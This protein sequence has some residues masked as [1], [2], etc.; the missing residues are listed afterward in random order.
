[1]SRKVKKYLVDLHGC[2]SREDVV[3]KTAAALIGA[4]DP[5]LK[6]GYGLTQGHLDALHEVV[7]EWFVA[8]WGEPKEILVKGARSV[9]HID[10]VLP[11]MIVDVLHCGF[12][13]A[14]LQALENGQDVAEELK[15]TRFDVDIR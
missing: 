10:A 14:V 1:M 7:S 6:D 11:A 13:S 15:R 9:A 12:E 2:T 8:H 5:L 4:D 3:R